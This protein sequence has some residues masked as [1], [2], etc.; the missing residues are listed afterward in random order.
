MLET[1]FRAGS[2]KGKF[3]WQTVTLP[4][5]VWICAATDGDGETRPAVPLSFAAKMNGA[6]A[7]F[8]VDACEAL[9]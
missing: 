4:G 5:S 3:P 8:K 7:W 1:S 9:A 2:R 6:N